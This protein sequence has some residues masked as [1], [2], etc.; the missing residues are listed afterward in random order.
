[1]TIECVH[2]TKVFRQGKR[3]V[4]AIRGV[5]LCIGAGEFVA[6]M[7]PSGS[8]K[9]TLLHLLGTLDRPT[10]GQVLLDG[11][12]L[13]RWSDRACALLRRTRLGFV[14]QLFHLVPTLNVRDNVALPLLLAGVSHGEAGRQAEAALRE[15]ELT[16]RGEHSPEELSGGEMQRVAIARA[17]VVEPDWV[18]CDEPTGSL[19]SVT[20]RGILRLLRRVPQSGTRSV[21]MVTHDRQAAEFADRILHVR[22][23]LIESEET[24]R[25]RSSGAA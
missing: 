17:L 21:V 1:M 24:V 16:G 10:T 11:S 3:P 23:G 18:L 4:E 14:F 22:D 6:L 12:D 20:G 8:G 19:D 9:S 5:S 13:S 15:V 2:V 25:V 7:G